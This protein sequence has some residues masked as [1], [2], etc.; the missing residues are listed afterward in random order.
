M[1]QALECELEKMKEVVFL[2][3]R[4]PGPNSVYFLAALAKALLAMPSFQFSFPE[5]CFTVH[6]PPWDVSSRMF[7]FIMN[8]ELAGPGFERF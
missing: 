6:C 4:K 2:C 5:P 8:Q 1:S 3:N 7:H